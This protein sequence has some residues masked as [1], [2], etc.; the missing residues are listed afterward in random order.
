M[1][2]CGCYEEH[3]LE[4]KRCNGLLKILV[5]FYLHHSL[6]IVDNA[7]MVTTRRICYNVNLLDSCSTN[8]SE[9][10]IRT[11]ISADMTNLWKN[12]NKI[13]LTIEPTDVDIEF[14]KYF[15]FVHHSNKS[16]IF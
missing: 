6:R 15:D 9:L 2:T 12:I 16:T 14:G 1:L 8:S 5:L 10:R 7:D 11:R 4:R 3:T 13:A